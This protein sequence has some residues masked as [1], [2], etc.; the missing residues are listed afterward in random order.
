[1]RICLQSRQHTLTLRGSNLRFLQAMP[2]DGQ[3]QLRL[4]DALK[5]PPISGHGNVNEII[6]RFGGTD[7]P[8]NAV[9]NCN[10]C[11]MRHE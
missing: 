3:L 6:G 9:N 11:Y 7:Q 4:L 1:M 5:D 2:T 8:R 10:R